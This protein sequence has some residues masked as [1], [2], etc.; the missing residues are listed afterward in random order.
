MRAVGPDSPGRDLLPDLNA[1]FVLENDRPE[2]GFLKGER[3][4]A[5]T[6]SEGAVPGD[7]AQFQIR[8]PV[9]SG[10]I[11]VITLM[12]GHN[13][14]A[15]ASQFEL[16]LAATE[17]T[18][19]AGA[20]GAVDTRWGTGAARIA[21]VIESENVDALTGTVIFR[22]SYANRSVPALFPF[23]IVLAPG[24]SIFVVDILANSISQLSIVGYERALET[25]ELES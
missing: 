14:T 11:S 12:Q 16:R 9:A 23:P 8:N 7:F 13:N 24:T 2:W 6:A 18:R 22:S 19:S 20:I 25:Y 1:A 15:G 17:G 21:T 4:F 5:G 3:R 10:M